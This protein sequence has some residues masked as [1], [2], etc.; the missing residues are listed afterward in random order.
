MIGL[1]F[2]ELTLLGLS[3]NLNLPQIL[4]NVNIVH[5]SKNGQIC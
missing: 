4:Q 3:L 1:S 2:I 5:F